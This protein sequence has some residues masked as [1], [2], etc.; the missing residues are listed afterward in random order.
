MKFLCPK[1]NLFLFFL[2]IFGFLFVFFSPNS[3]VTKNVLAIGCTTSCVTNLNAS[4]TGSTVNFTITNPA[5]AGWTLLIYNSPIAPGDPAVGV[6]PFA[7]NST[8][9]SWT[10]SNGNYEA[11]VNWAT[12]DISN[13]VNFTIGGG[14]PGGGFTIDLNTQLAGKLPTFGPASVVTFI[15]QILI[16]AAF[17]VAFIFLLLGGI[18]WITAGGDEK[19]IAGAR[20]MITGA[21][22]GL[23]IVL[24]AFT[25]VKLIEYFF[26]VKIISGTLTIPSIGGP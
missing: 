8:S 5:G 19:A 23:I 20:G 24:A 16:V 12:A 21:L 25:I 13:A 15:V 2:L 10:G 1:K 7:L 22:I 6:V 17:I 3:L 18:R 14:G 4:T 9:A 26:N 11:V